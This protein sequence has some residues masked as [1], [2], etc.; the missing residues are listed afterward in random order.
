[1]AR[2]FLSGERAA[3]HGD[4]V[5]FPFKAIRAVLASTHKEVHE[6]GRYGCG[7]GNL[8][9]RPA[10]QVN[11]N[12]VVVAADHDVI[13]GTDFNGRGT[14]EPRFGAAE[15]ELARAADAQAIWPE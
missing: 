9:D 8:R 4:L 14:L 11:R 2:R 5:Q 13:P 1:M 15:E 3:V 6:V 7:A 10:V 12:L